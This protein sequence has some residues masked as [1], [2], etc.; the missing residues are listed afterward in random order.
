MRVNCSFKCKILPLTM[1]V[2]CSFKCMR[3][4]HRTF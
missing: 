1:R 2:N 4:A 3:P